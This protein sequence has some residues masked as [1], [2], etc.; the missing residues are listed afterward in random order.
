MKSKFI[1]FNSILIFLLLSLT[2]INNVTAQNKLYS[3][4]KQYEIYQK[5]YK[6]YSN[7]VEK[8]SELTNKYLFECSNQK[9]LIK[10]HYMWKQECETKIKEYSKDEKRYNKD[11]KKW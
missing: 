6:D 9:L 4:S 11:L 10:S 8:I 3:E 7:L 2:S 1:S 5:M